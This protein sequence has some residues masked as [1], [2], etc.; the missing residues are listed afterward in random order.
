[1][2]YMLRPNLYQVVPTDDYKVYLYYDN[3]EIKLYDCSWVLEQ[4]GV[5]EK[6]HNIEDFKRF[7]TIINGTLGFDYT[8]KRDTYNC[9]DID[10]DTV[11][12]ESIKAEDIFDSQ[13]L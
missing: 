6:I 12:E 1:M 13:S 10:P 8:E 9:I 2:I 7:C 3:G 11:Y 5:F 4:K